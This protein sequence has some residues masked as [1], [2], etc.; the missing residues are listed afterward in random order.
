MV[1]IGLDMDREDIE[2]QLDACLLTDD[3]MM[4]DWTT[5]ADP[6]PPFVAAN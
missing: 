2:A 4:S 1:W 6:I 5:F 3:E